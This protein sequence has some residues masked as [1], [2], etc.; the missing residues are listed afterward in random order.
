MVTGRR[1]A[2]AIAIILALAVGGFIVTVDHPWT[3]G[4]AEV[5]TRQPA[6]IIDPRDFPSSAPVLTSPTPLADSHVGMRIQLPQ[7][8]IN[9]PI[10]EG[11]GFNAPLYEAAH[12]PGTAWPGEDA[13]SVIYAHARVGMFGPL[14]GA[15]VGDQVV[16]DR[17]DGPPLDY[18]I[19]QYYPSWPITDTSILQPLDQ[20]E[21]VL[22]T[23]TTYNYNDPRIVAVA[24]PQ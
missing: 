16:I 22:I 3:H 11:D 15:K 18:V 8:G 4:A 24:F 23:C 14:F 12:Y 10:V 17:P 2:L 13:R 5:A 20:P 19:K 21:I 9:L 6:Q 1:A 7:L